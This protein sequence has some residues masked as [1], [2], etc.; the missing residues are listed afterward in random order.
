[1]N[2]RIAI[3]D[4]GMGNLHSV[5]KA[6][7]RMANGADV[8]IVAD[9][10][11]LAA[12]DRVVF[13]GVGSIRDCMAALQQQ[14]LITTLRDCLHNKPV[15]AICVGMQALFKSS[16]EN[17][18]VE[19][20]NIFPGKVIRF[21]QN[22]TQSLKIPHMG[23]NQVKQK[24]PQHP[25]WKGIADQSRFYFVHSYHATCVPEQQVIATC[26]YISDFPCA[27]AQDNVCAV[28]FHPE[29]SQQLGLQLLHNFVHHVK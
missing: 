25:L 1:M 27:I 29:K 17:D 28:Q 19:C 9:K 6:V 5:A 23:W 21:Q 10:Q 20:L 12:A 26:I 2:T 18:G 3:L 8:R 11:G 7:Q 13:P 22:P 4:Y 14:D 16:E 24:Q 15:L